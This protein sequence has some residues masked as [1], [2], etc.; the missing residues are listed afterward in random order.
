M[1][2]Q[3]KSTAFSDGGTIPRRFTCDGEGLSPPLHWSDVPA[4]ARSLV[5]L[6]DDPDAPART[7][8][9]WASYDIP[10]SQTALPES[11][12]RLGRK[13]EMKQANNDFGR[14]G[15]GGPCPPRGHGAHRYHFRL[16]ALSTDRLAVRKNPSC[17]DVERE[18]RKHLIAEAIL[19]ALY[20]R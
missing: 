13:A 19:V 6:C 5:L 14:L 9:H 11:A 2:M 12:G 20:E 7:W 10:A 16:L 18:A 4:G 3:L 17:Q 15:Y 8:H 1:A